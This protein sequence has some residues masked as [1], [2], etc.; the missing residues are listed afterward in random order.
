M[1]VVAARSRPGSRRK[2]SA[3]ASVASQSTTIVTPITLHR[4]AL[5]GVSML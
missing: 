5:S 2:R 3:T 4:A 1:A